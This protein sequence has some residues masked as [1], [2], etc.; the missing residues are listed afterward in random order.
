[1]IVKIM[2]L[3]MDKIV[4]TKGKMVEKER[5]VLHISTSLSAL[6]GYNYFKFKLPAAF[7]SRSIPVFFPSIVTIRRSAAI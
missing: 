6:K 2:K 4:L 7:F 3:K 5:D 1:M